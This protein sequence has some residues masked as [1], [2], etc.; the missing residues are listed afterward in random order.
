MKEA[1]QQGFKLSRNAEFEATPFIADEICYLPGEARPLPA[2]FVLEAK[3]VGSVRVCSPQSFADLRELSGIEHSSFFGSLAEED[4][5]G[6]STQA[7]GKSGSLFWFSADS[8]FV[9]KS[10]TEKELQ[11]LLDM[12]P[13][14]AQHLQDNTDS[15]LTRFLGA[16]CFTLYEGGDEVR[17]VVMNN[18][19]EGATQHKL[20]DLK[21]TT[22]DR[23]VEEAPGKCLKDLNFEDV[24][25]YMNA[26][27]HER[28][29]AVLLS[30]TCFLEQ[31]DI[32]DYSLILSIQYS[33]PSRSA[34]KDAHRANH[35]KPFSQL[36]GGLEG[37]VCRETQGQ[38]NCRA[39]VFHIGLIDMLTTYSTRKQIA[40][41]WK[42]NT[43]GYFCEIDT[44]PPDV[45][46]ERFRNH[47]MGKLLGLD[48]E[49]RPTLLGR[50]KSFLAGTSFAAD[51]PVMKRERSKRAQ[52]ARPDGPSSPAIASPKVVCL[53]SVGQTMGLLFLGIAG[54]SSTALASPKLVCGSP[55]SLGG[56]APPTPR[57]S[58]SGSFFALAG[59][60]FGGTSVNIL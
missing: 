6:G 52:S 51:S 17:V 15:L 58:E 2:E 57:S 44:Q 55:K 12:L 23:W 36:M 43:I 30:D 10:V 48:D 27:V 16:Y 33:S 13:K 50:L 31:L 42:S 28:L 56:S 29:H 25:L 40:H 11:N 34:S 41:A 53:P 8:R 3:P 1:I 22:E 24:S 4:L 7:S 59:M 60:S 19:L 49:R 5:L 26:E 47:F 14:Y 39:C 18:V 20:Y 37:T 38:G 32:M 9:L 21:G 45:Y 54:P 35:P 46:A